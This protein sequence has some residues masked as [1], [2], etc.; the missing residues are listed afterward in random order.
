MR[1]LVPQQE[2]QALAPSAPTAG[3][4]SRVAALVVEVGA[5]LRQAFDSP[6]ILEQAALLHHTPSLVLGR[7]ATDRLLHDLF[8]GGTPRAGSPR[9]EPLPEKLSAVL[10]DFRQFPCGGTDREVRTMSHILAICNL[11]D[12]QIELLPYESKPMEELWR[13][14]DGLGALVEPEVMDAVRKTIRG[15]RPTINTKELPVQISVVKEM[16]ELLRGPRSGDS[17]ALASLAS[18]DPGTAASFLQVANSALYQ[19]TKRDPEHPASR[20][21][22]RR[23]YQPPIAAGAGSASVVR[24]VAS[25]GPVASLGGYGAIVGGIRAPLRIRRPGGGAVG[26]VSP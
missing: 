23:G 14:I 2:L 13:G 17:T 12:E 24:V 4:C 6:A 25:E 22:S 7:S 8:P 11:V 19:K 10:S 20:Y 9:N 5:A 15:R 26:W 3:H 1:F 16:L 21:I 18:R